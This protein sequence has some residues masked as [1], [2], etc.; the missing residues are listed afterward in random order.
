MHDQQR[1]VV[2][3]E[4]DAQADKVAFDLRVNVAELVGGEERRVVVEATG[5]RGGEFEDRG[6]FGEADLA[7]GELGGL[8]GDVHRVV[9]RGDLVA[10]ASCRRL[11]AKLF[12]LVG[13][14]ADAVGRAGTSG[15]PG[16][17]RGSGHRAGTGPARA[18][19]CSS[20][21]RSCASRSP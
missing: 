5:G 16:R 9:P 1:P 4:L 19:W 3:L 21:C 18:A 2:G 13:A 6:R 11:G 20:G 17:C 15:R 8:R 10:A 12:D 7:A 14:G